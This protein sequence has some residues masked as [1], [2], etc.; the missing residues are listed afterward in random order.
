MFLEEI[1]LILFWTAMALFAFYIKV[2]AVLLSR[3]IF[4]R[5]FRGTVFQ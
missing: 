3:N 2:H 1:G 5:E 4:S